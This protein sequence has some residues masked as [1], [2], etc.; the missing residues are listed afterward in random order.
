MNKISTR[1]NKIYLDVLGF[2][3][4]R[5]FS[6][7]STYKEC[8]GEYE[9]AEYIKAL[10]SQTKAIAAATSLAGHRAHIVRREAWHNSVLDRS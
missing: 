1:T 6:V 9:F 3:S 10:N 5:S 4:R 2:N 7:F 8:L